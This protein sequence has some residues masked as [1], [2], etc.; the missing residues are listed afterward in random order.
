MYELVY[1]RFGTVM[2]EQHESKDN[3]IAAWA[4]GSDHND[5]FSPGFV[6]RDQ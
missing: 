6:N 5:F 2:T 4:I 1:W 3:A